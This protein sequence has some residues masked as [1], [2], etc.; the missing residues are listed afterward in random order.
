VAWKQAGGP[1]ARL[2]SRSILLGEYTALVAREVISLAPVVW[3]LVA[4]VG[5]LECKDAVPAGERCEWLAILGPR[6]MKQKS[7]AAC[8]AAADGAVVC[9]INFNAPRPSGYCR[10]WPAAVDR[11][12]IEC[13][14][15]KALSR[16][17][18]LSFELRRRIVRLMRPAADELAKCFSH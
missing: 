9:R 4:D 18:P 11:A 2:F 6:I 1:A 10:Q 14:A 17:L 5:R 7:I 15:A 13:K 8:K 3:R 16:A 12:I